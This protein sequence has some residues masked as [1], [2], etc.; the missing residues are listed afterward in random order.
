MKTLFIRDRK[1]RDFYQ[2]RERE[3]V[4]WSELFLEIVSRGV[5]G[6]LNR[7]N[8][9]DEILSEIINRRGT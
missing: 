2:Q 4:Y 5:G 3:R 1:T 8:E 6:K 7:E 9:H